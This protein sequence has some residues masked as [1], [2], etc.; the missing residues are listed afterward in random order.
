MVGFGTRLTPAIALGATVKYIRFAFHG[1]SES[2]FG[3]DIGIHTRQQSASNG[4][5]FN[6]FYGRHRSQRE[7]D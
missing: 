4:R 6:G 5:F 1:F 3:S 7:F 2:G